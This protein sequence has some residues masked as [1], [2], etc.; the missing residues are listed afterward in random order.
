MTI[1][2][3]NGAFFSRI[4]NKN[5]SYPLCVTGHKLVFSKQKYT[6]D[7]AVYCVSSRKECVKWKHSIVF[8]SRLFSPL[9]RIFMRSKSPFS[10]NF[11]LSEIVGAKT[12]RGDKPSIW[13][14]VSRKRAWLG[15]IRA[16]FFAA[17]TGICLEENGKTK[18]ELLTCDIFFIC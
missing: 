15:V 11:R 14:Y 2:C 9:N 8:N 6:E 17:D 3:A 1:L 13:L 10:L 16:F 12:I 5:E 4:T 7:A 18:P